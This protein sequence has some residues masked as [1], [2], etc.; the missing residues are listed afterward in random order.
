MMQN[1]IIYSDDSGFRIPGIGELEETFLKARNIMN[2]VQLMDEE[3][4]VTVFKAFQ[5]FEGGLSPSDK[6]LLLN[7]LNSILTFISRDQS[8]I[9][10]ADSTVV[11]AI[12]QKQTAMVELQKNYGV[13]LTMAILI[14]DS[15]REFAGLIDQNDPY[16]T[17]WICNFEPQEVLGRIMRSRMLSVR[18]CQNVLLRLI[19]IKSHCETS[20]MVFAIPPGGAVVKPK[21]IACPG[22]CV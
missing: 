21:I 14:F 17:Q 15:R 2:A 4:F 13:D 9:N 19:A 16:S 3:G 22:G 6:G 10:E 11:N 5:M 12:A 8:F 18:D 20:N 1:E 7:C